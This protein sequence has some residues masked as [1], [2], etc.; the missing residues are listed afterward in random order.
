MSAVHF[1]SADA[2]PDKC[3]VSR[4]AK[5]LTL[6]LAKVCSDEVQRVAHW[7]CMKHG[8][9]GAIYIE[10]SNTEA[11][12]GTAEWVVRHAKEY[13]ALRDQGPPHEAFLGGD[14]ADKALDKAN[15][16]E[17]LF[18]R[19]SLPGLLKLVWVTEEDEAAQ[20]D[21]DF[22]AVMTNAGDFSSDGG[23]VRVVVQDG[24]EEVKHRRAG[25]TSVIMPLSYEELH[26]TR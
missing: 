6:T 7:Q 17:T 12:L 1:V 25:I 4:A 11:V 14:K 21:E 15:A 3:K 5:F 13:N 9:E 2:P 24:G 19:Q 23:V 26:P 22:R 8:W 18:L 20:Q 16:L 10:F